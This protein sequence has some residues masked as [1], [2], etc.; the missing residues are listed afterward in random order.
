[1]PYQNPEQL[2]LIWGKLP[3]HVSGDVGAS[4]PEFVDYRDQNLVF[5]S[6]AAYTSSSFNLSGVG[7]PERIVGTFVSAS[8]FPLLDVQ[9]ALGRAFLNEEDRPGHD[10]VAI[11]S[12][13]LWRRRFPGDSAVIGRS[14]SL[15]G[16]SHTIIGGGPAGVRFPDDGSGNRET[17][18]FAAQLFSDT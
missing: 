18:A 3:A 8:L 6:V 12:H 11:L 17:I 5:S 14:V 10:R 16:Q 4:A 1:L 7:E 13:G 15:D 2:A 9:P